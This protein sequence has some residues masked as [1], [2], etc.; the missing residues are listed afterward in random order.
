MG[1][2][3]CSKENKDA[4]VQEVEKEF[5]KKEHIKLFDRDDMPLMLGP[6]VRP[7]VPT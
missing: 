3:C 1:S 7:K 2:Y 5:L 6:T 4:K